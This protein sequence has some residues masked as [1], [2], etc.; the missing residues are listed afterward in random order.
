MRI[1]RQ[2]SNVAYSV[3]SSHQTVYPEGVRVVTQNLLQDGF[4]SGA[5]ER[6]PGQNQ[7]LISRYFGTDMSA[8]KAAGLANTTARVR[9]I[10][11]IQSVR[12]ALPEQLR[13]KYLGQEVLRLKIAPSARTG[14]H[15]TKETK[16]ILKKKARQ[17]VTPEYRKR[18][19]EITQGFMTQ[20]VKD[21]IRET[22]KK[23]MTKKRREKIGRALRGPRNRYHYT[24][25]K[26]REA[27]NRRWLM[28]KD[29]TPEQRENDPLYGA[30]VNLRFVNG[31][32]FPKNI[33]DYFEASPSAYLEWEPILAF[34]T[35]IRYQEG[36]L[37]Y[38]TV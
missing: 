8:S 24:S 32:S 4:D 38:I 5:F 36:K 3:V 9:I 14:W 34:L 7:E 18:Q 6:L 1:E 33:R 20:G 13:Q 22:A 16:R 25:E 23:R 28:R 19:G 21:K 30:I 35:L 29:L 27:A 15:H 11:A 2:P 31:D 10:N 12:D 26:A 37:W 17:R